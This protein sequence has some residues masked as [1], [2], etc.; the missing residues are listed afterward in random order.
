LF[1]GVTPVP[2]HEAS[3]HK[4][5]FLHFQQGLVYFQRADSVLLRFAKAF[6]CHSFHFHHKL[7]TMAPNVEISF[8]PDEHCSHPRHHRHSIED[9]I[10]DERWEKVEKRLLSDPAEIQCVRLEN[11]DGHQTQAYALHYLCRKKETPTPLLEHFVDLH[12]EAV[13]TPDSLLQEL[14]IHVAC[15][16]DAPVAFLKV[17]VNAYPESL[18]KSDKD[19]NLPIHYACALESPDAAHYLMNA[20]AESTKRVN[21]KNQTPLHLACSRYDVSISLIQDLIDLN[22]NA[23]KT[24]D[25]Q[26]RLPIHSACMWKASTAVIELLLRAYPQSVREKDDHNMNPYG[27]CRKVVH[28]DT[29]HATVKLLRD[30]HKK[31]ASLLGKGKDLVQYHAENLSDA[32]HLHHHPSFRHAN[33][34]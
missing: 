26:A 19:G 30:H 15:Q 28:L 4:S 33:A 14:P 25:W 17:L 18:L 20:S 1:S 29:H 12:H 10:K 3:P 21:K 7:E 31:H 6:I 13:S 34:F 16:H 9:L 5:G 2:A 27:I 8:V 32:L 24:R 22:E 23:C 11:I